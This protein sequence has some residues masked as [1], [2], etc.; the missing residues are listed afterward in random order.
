[1]MNEFHF[2]TNIKHLINQANNLETPP[3]IA[4]S[5]NWFTENITV[6]LLRIYQS[7]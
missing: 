4:T 7:S 5:I 1:M 2:A 6:Q 3:D